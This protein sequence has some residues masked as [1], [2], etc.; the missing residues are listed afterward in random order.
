MKRPAVRIQ[1]I[2]S[3]LMVL[4]EGVLLGGR[5]M[6]FRYGDKIFLRKTDGALSFARPNAVAPIEF[7]YTGDDRFITCS[8]EISRIQALEIATIIARRL[9]F[10][11]AVD[12]LQDPSKDGKEN[13]YYFTYVLCPGVA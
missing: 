7:P 8:C 5:Q 9:G 4:R 11:I 1:V 6:A 2:K 3:I 10:S 12:P 13:P